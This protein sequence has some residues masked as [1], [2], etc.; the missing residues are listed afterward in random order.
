MLVPA[1]RGFPSHDL[2][3]EALATG[4]DLLWRV[5]ASFTLPVIERL[6]DGTYLSEVRGR[7]KK[8]R[9]AVR[10]IEYSVRDDDGI[11]EAFALITNLLDADEAPPSN[12]P[13]TTARDGR[14]S[15]SSA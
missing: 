2:Y 8:G 1:D 9:V 5:S 6:D 11:S 7:R 3:V 15:C 13:A 12:W 10:V 4:A 14:S